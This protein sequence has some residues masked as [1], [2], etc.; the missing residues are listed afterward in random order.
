MV[1]SKSLLM[2]VEDE[3]LVLGLLE[4]ALTDA[5]FEVVAATNGTRAIAELDA[6]AT[7]FAAVVTDIRLGQGP[8]GWTVAR[9]ARVLMPHVAVVYISG[10][11]LHDWQR[12]GVTG[13]AYLPKPF[14]P[15]SLISVISK[16]LKKAETNRDGS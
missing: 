15:G 2:L 11:S 4:D 14:L 16:L 12:K 13:S 8:D 3:P 7:P 9:R 10:D 6:A 5:G 1:G